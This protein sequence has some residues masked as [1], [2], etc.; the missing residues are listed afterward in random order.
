MRRLGLTLALLAIAVLLALSPAQAGPFGFLRGRLFGRG[1]G[2]VRIG[3]G[4]AGC[5]DSG[6]YDTGRGSHCQ[7]APAAKANDYYEHQE[8]GAAAADEPPAPVADP[9]TDLPPG[10]PS[11]EDEGSPSDAPIAPEDP[12]P[13]A[14]AAAEPPVA[15]PPVAELPVAE[16]PVEP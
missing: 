1:C 10:E 2:P 4:P 9:P 7:A 12:A 15:E 11:A 6:C 14:E 8:H 5:R 16:L 3:C 13:E